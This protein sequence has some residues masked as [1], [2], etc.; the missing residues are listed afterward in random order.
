MALDVELAEV[1]DFLAAHEP[2]S[3]LPPEVLSGLPRRMGLEYVRRGSQLI[4]RGADN[5]HLHVLRS[6]AADVHDAQGTLVDRGEAGSSF[7][8][9]TLTQGNPS[10]FSVTAIEDCLVLLLPEDDFHALCREHADFDAFYDAQRRSRMRGAVAELQVSTSGSAILRTTVRELVG[11]DVVSVVTTASIREAAEVMSDQ[12]VSSLLVMDGE[13]LAGIVTDRDLRTRVLAA[14]VDPDVAVTEVMTADPV[15]GSVEALAFEALLAMTS[16]HIHHLPVLDVGGRPAG[17]VTTT[18]LLRLE[19]AN[20][21]YLAGDVA[22]QPDVEGVARAASRL[23]RVVQALVEQDASADDIGRVVTA[24]GDAVERRVLFLAEAVLGPPPVPYCW[25]ALG[26]R[27]R[28]EQALATDQ[29]HAMIVDDA[30]DED[31]LAWFEDL[32]E[33]VTGALVRC[34]Y[35]RCAGDVMATNPRWRRPL[36][37]WRRELAGWFAAPTPD[38]VLHSSI[39][40]DMR[41]VHGEESLHARL[42]QFVLGAAPG[43]RTYLTHLAR[44]AASHE[45]PLGFFRGLVLEKEGVHKDTLDIKRGGLLPVV[46]LARVHALATGVAAVNTR[47][48]LEAVREAGVV[49]DELAGDLRDA[50]EFLGYVRLRHQSAQ[51]RAGLPTDNFVS[52]ADLSSF[53]KRHLREAFA[54]VRSAQQSLGRA[55]QTQF[56]S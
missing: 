50:F 38:A 40:F 2:F 34:G 24:V 25:V 32:A 16:R 31:G 4:A 30:V 6:G 49:G 41:P 27:A 13:R 29:D 26:S 15:T 46:E 36:E 56:V 1:R 23:P 17:V 55:Y 35:P 48:R 45:P 18:D 8:S 33:W 22:K 5:H 47:S 21:V 43:A 20:P 19:E 14:G 3:A 12:G 39:V 37:Q 42:R 53:E 7:G 51:V 28:L 54:I 9:I 52:P 44:Q 11:R 10:T